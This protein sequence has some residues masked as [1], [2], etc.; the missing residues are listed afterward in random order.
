MDQEIC[1][2]NHRKIR[3]TEQP[4]YIRH[5]P[6]QTFIQIQKHAHAIKVFPD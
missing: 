1:T 5:P 2:I 3:M 6:A 4:S